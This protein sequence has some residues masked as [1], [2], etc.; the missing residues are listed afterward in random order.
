MADYPATLPPP[1]QNGY[2]LE[3][4][5][6][7]VEITPYNGLSFVMARSNDDTT[8]FSVR[9]NFDQA[10]YDT[11]INWFESDL[12]AG[13][14]PFNIDLFIES[15][16]QTQ[17]AVFVADSMNGFRAQNY[18]RYIVEAQLFVS[19]INDPDTGEYALLLELA[20]LDAT[21]DAENA[22]IDVDMAINEVLP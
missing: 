1:L 12:N 10:Q 3:K 7:D 22:M 6:N 17:S 11:F 2:Q 18:N 8:L 5:S 21:G 9:W 16:M 19:S 14:L 13:E 4:P 15:G 20:G